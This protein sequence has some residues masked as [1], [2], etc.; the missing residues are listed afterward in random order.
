MTRYWDARCNTTHKEHVNNALALAET[1]ECQQCIKICIS[2][3]T[4]IK[5]VNRSS[6]FHISWLNVFYLKTTFWQKKFEQTYSVA[7]DWSKGADEDGVERD[8]DESVGKTG[9]P[10][11]RSG[12]ELVAVAWKHNV[13][14]CKAW[15]RKK[16]S[17]VISHTPPEGW[18]RAKKFF[19][20][21]NTTFWSYLPRG[22][23]FGVSRKCGIGAFCTIAKNSGEIWKK[24]PK[25]GKIG[26][27]FFSHPNVC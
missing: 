18:V 2:V 4:G 5:R 7:E 23:K 27:K 10:A 6:Y 16:C 25:K 20:T 21:S 3:N 22:T 13:S 24:C 17:N 15:P 9:H 26:F 19:I 11:S 1:K 8:T 14:I 12:C